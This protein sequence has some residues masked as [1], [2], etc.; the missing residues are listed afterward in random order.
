MMTPSVAIFSPG[1][2]TNSSPTREIARRGSA[3]STPSRSTATSFAPMS[4]R[5]RMRGAGL[6]LGALLEVAAQQDEHG[7]PGGRPRGRCWPRRR[8]AS[9]VNSKPWVI[10]G[11]PAVP[12][13][14]AYSDQRNA[15]MRAHRDQGVHGRRAVAQ[16]RPRG[17]VERPGAPRRSRVRSS[18]SNAHCQY[19]NCSAGDHRHEDHRH[20]QDDRDDQTLA[21]RCELGIF[22]GRFFLALAAGSWAEYPVFSTSAMSNDAVDS[23]LAAVTRR[24]LSRIVDRRRD[25]IELVEFALDP[26]SRTR[27]R[28]CHRSRVRRWSSCSL[29]DGRSQARTAE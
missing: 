19:V 5:A 6:A 16:V 1:R 8:S 7:H 18:A 2:T 27:R 12:K 9:E 15:A 4:S 14:S 20:R 29:W 28:S 24:L 25:A 23:L 17:P 26:R 11:L 21:E 10:P 22:V 3:I 13:N